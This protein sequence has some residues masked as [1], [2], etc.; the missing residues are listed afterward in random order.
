LSHEDN[1]HSPEEIYPLLDKYGTR[2]VVI[3]DRPTGSTVLDWLRDEVKGDR[4]IERRRIRIA[5]T[6]RR[7]QG[8]D[9]VVYEYKDAKPADFNTVLDIKV[10]LVGRDIRLRLSDLQPAAAR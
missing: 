7:L 2:F 1:I 3:E 4:F 6:D 10:P 9:L 5:T 8:V